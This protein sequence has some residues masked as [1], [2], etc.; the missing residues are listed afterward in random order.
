[1]RSTRTAAWKV[2]HV[3]SVDDSVWSISAC[4]HLMLTVYSRACTSQNRSPYGRFDKLNNW[5]FAKRTV[6]SPAMLVSQGDFHRIHS[7]CDPHTK[8]ILSLLPF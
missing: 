3:P 1:M 7:I 5:R 4:V 6:S 2:V 8:S